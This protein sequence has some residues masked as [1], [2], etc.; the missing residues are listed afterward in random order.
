MQCFG[1]FLMVFHFIY[2]SFLGVGVGRIH[3]S[4][5]YVPS[6]MYCPQGHGVPWGVFHLYVC[7]QY[8]CAQS[9][10]LRLAVR[11]SIFCIADLLWDILFICYCVNVLYDYLRLLSLIPSVSHLSKVVLRIDKQSVEIGP[12]T[13]VYCS[14]SL[15]TPGLMHWAFGFRTS[16]R[17]LE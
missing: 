12:A 16:F 3:F 5:T 11:L 14:R 10:W 7:I 9:S 8:M 15:M 6:C 1:Q 2:T 17:D 13:S 4:V